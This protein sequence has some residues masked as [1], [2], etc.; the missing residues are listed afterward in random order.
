[1]NYI[2]ISQNILDLSLNGFTIIHNVY[3]EEEINIYWSLFN[4]WIKS[5]D[6]LEYHHSLIDYNGIFKHHEVGHQRFAWLARTNPKILNIFKQLWNTNE[7]VTSFD[8]CCYYPSYY[9]Q[10]PSFWTHTDQSPR[11]KG[12]HCYQSI[13][14]M[15]DNTQRTFIAYKGSHLLHENYFKD[16]NIDEPRDWYVFDEEYI[17]T[18]QHTK[19]ILNIKKGDLLVWDSRTYHQNTCGDYNSNEERLVQYLCFL[20]KNHPS[21]NEEQQKKRFNLFKT[22]R[23]TSHWPYPLIPVPKQANLYNYYNPDTP[24]NIDYQSLPIPDIDDLH[25]EI[26]KLL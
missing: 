18:L 11:K 4:N 9:Y 15:T 20:P 1:M 23:T 16:N 7:L 22:Y 24:I 2:D 14:S 19:Q 3:N 25:D 17:N 12:V 8:G 26:Y 21:N 10:L 13:L 6:N 5:I